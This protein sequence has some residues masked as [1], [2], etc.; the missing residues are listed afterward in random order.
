MMDAKENAA[1]L[2]KHAELTGIGGDGAKHIWVGNKDA[3]L[4]GMANALASADASVLSPSVS[5]PSI[6]DGDDGGATVGGGSARLM[7]SASG[8]DGMARVRRSGVVTSNS[9]G[10]TSLKLRTC[11]A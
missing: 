3:L 4:S 8:G 6:D 2:R 9:S 10:S 11:A 7:T 5:T 1:P